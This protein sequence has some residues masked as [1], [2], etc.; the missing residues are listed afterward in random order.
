MEPRR[1]GGPIAVASFRRAF[2][3]SGPPGGV[4]RDG[5]GRLSGEHGS[6]PAHPHRCGVPPR[7]RGVLAEE[8]RRRFRAGTIVVSI[9][10]EIEGLAGGGKP[11]G[12]GHPVEH[13][14]GQDTAERNRTHRLGRDESQRSEQPG[15]LR[16][17]GG[18]RDE[19]VHH[20]AVVVVRGFRHPAAV[21]GL[22]PHLQGRDDPG[23]AGLS[24][25]DQGPPVLGET[26]GSGRGVRKRPVVPEPPG[27]LFAT[28]CDTHGLDREGDAGPAAGIAT[29]VL[30]QQ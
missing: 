27:V 26:P 12:T 28:L 19:R 14:R 29:I 13:R 9:A 23:G 24:E 20:P 16:T 22:H 7:N 21:Q 17:K 8:P 1:S 30:R 3:L 10:T 11:S 18:G 4:F 15:T 6:P 2:C 5:P 25:N